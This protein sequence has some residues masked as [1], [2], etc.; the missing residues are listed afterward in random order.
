MKNDEGLTTDVHRASIVQNSSASTSD[1]RNLTK[2]VTLN[3]PLGYLFSWTVCCAVNTLTKHLALKLRVEW[4]LQTTTKRQKKEK[5]RRRKISV[6]SLMIR[7]TYCK[8]TLV[9]KIAQSYWNSHLVTKRRQKMHCGESGGH[10]WERIFCLF[11]QICSG[12]LKK[13]Y[14]CVSRDKYSFTDWV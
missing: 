7:F 6:Q 5:K 13:I 10:Q 1:S 9:S 2:R 11:G 12:D 8:E 3:G 14:L 4:V